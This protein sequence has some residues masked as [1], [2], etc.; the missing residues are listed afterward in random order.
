MTT[1]HP[2]TLSDLRVQDNVISLPTGKMIEAEANRWFH[3]IFH[4]TDPVFIR[5]LFS[6][7]G[8]KVYECYQDP[9]SIDY[10]YVI[11]SY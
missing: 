7:D 6:E 1:S 2:K 11:V 3:E 9:G 8:K 10:L 5:H 4:P